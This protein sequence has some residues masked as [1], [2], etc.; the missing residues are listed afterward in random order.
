MDEMNLNRV[1]SV[2]GYSRFI[3]RQAIQPLLE[4]SPT[5]LLTPVLGNMFDILDRCPTLPA[6]FGYTGESRS[7]QLRVQFV[8]V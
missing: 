4:R 3:M 5:E 8:D 6:I 2:Y 7:Q 1:K